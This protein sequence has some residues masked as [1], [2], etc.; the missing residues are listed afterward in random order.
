MTQ[1]TKKRLTAPDCLGIKLR[2]ARKRRNLE[3]R[4]VEVETKV[5][6]R[7]LEALENG[8]YDA[9]PAPV[10][11][12]GFLVR[13]ATFLGLK[14]EAVLAD[15]DRERSSYNQVRHVRQSKHQDQEGLLRPHVADDWL[16]RSKQWYVTP[17]VLWGGTASVGLVFVLSYIWFQVASFAAAPPLEIVTPAAQTVVTTQDVEVAGVTDPGATLAINRQT[18]AVDDQGHFRQSIHLAEGVN[19]IEIAATSPRDKETVKVIQLL[20]DLPQV[21]GPTNPN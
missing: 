8:R 7:H 5:A 12:R 17:E 16:H 11:V 20:A 3:L 15:Y 9:L 19:T 21:A 18:V 6:L 10:Y 13:Y 14:P 1:F 4:A 2:R